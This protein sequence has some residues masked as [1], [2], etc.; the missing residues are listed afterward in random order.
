MQLHGWPG[1][2]EVLFLASSWAR[3]FEAGGKS[4][5]G[6]G[7]Y[8][9]PRGGKKKERKKKRPLVNARSD[10][11][12]HHPETRAEKEGNKNPRNPTAAEARQTKKG[13]KSLSIHSTQRAGEL[14]ADSPTWIFACSPSPAS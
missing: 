6:G 4:N 2:D 3:G 13:S 8:W 7:E 5:S 11:N 1:L 10:T 9:N 14:E 12:H